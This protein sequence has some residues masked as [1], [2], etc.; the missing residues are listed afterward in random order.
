ME[1]VN[2]AEWERAARS[3][4]E[5]GALGYFAGGAGDERTLRANVAALERV[6]LRPRVL[7][8]VSTVDTSTT[9]LGT[10]VS[11]PLLL[12]PVAFQGLLH[13]QGERAGARAAAAAGTIFTL[14]TLASCLPREIA[15]AGARWMQLYVFRDRAI[16]RAIIDEAV[17]C[18]FC[19][20]VLTVDA[21]RAGRRERDL[22]TAF[23]LP[24]ELSV[25]SVAAA[26]GGGAT[27]TVAE[28]FELVDASLCWE[29]VAE[30]AATSPLPLVLKGIQTAEDARLACEH[31]ADAIVVSNH[32]GRQLDDVAGTIELLPE[33][34]DA[35]GGRSEVLMDGGVRRGID[36]LKALALG[37]RAV[38]VGR[39]MIW[40]LAAAGERGVARVLEQLHAEIEL[41][42]TLLGCPTP[43]DVTRMHVSCPRAT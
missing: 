16:T 14:S 39:P 23:Q 25:P 22:R 30:F 3:R 29:D 37:A 19:A 2:V 35:V 32:G 9:V 5:P 4:I 33:I 41:G 43:A 26:I 42:L 17:E 11:M 20:L 6:K 18:G 34:V 8:D 28:V 15:P 36:V 24:P 1:P 13:A 12:A 27:P 31:G 38:M 21:P 40:G 7:V 10:A